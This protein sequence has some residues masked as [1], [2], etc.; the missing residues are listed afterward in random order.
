MQTQRASQNTGS[1][2]GL[3]NRES[4]PLMYSLTLRPRQ[5][6]RLPA[7]FSHIRVLSGCA[8]VTS[9]QD[10]IILHQNEQVAFH[11]AG[12]LAVVITALGG[13]PLVLEVAQQ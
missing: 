12:S 11:P 10:D 5:V 3:F 4:E 1:V 7:Y 2:A 9:G 13:I 6:Y 8:W